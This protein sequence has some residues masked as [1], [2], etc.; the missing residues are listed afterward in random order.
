MI[1]TEGVMFAPPLDDDCGTKKLCSIEIF[2]KNVIY[3]DYNI[4]ASADGRL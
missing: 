3:I 4:I 2:G 1:V